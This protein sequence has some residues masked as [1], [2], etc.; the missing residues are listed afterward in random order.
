M[1]EV[2]LQ[3][4]TK[5]FGKDVVAV[6]NLDLTAADGEFV[7]LLGP[8]GCGK[9]TILRMIAG[10]ET[11]TEGEILIGGRRVTDVQPRDR[12]IAMVFQNYALYPHMTA[13]ENIAFGLRMRKMPLEEIEERIRWAAGFLEI[14]DMLD[15]R[16]RALSG[17]ERQRIALGRAL[18]RKPSV[19]LFD[20]P[21]SN[22]DARLRVQMRHEIIKIHRRVGTTA[23][24]VTHDQAEAMTMGDH[25]AVL[26]NG[27]LQQM[28]PP[29]ELYGTPAN[30]FVAEFV[31]NPAI[32]ILEGIFDP[33]AG[34]FS[35]AAFEF[36]WP[37]AVPKPQALSPVPLHFGIRPENVHLEPFRDGGP[38]IEVDCRVERVD[39]LGGEHHVYLSAGDGLIVSRQGGN[40]PLGRVENS[41]IKVRFDP[42]EGHF[43]DA[44]SG[45]NIRCVE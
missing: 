28:A 23:I 38:G 41:R 27:R 20:E 44:G 24:Y 45:G 26:H 16:P 15:R 11:V 18:V 29:A 30:R 3:G 10:L 43:F 35:C 1:A 9:T 31:G 7:V 14:D 32:N 17:G 33:A 21:L 8:S 37:A 6:D 40:L 12:D 34:T 39:L 19:F 4:V 5:R 42:E 22:L 2:R 13:Y 25:I 36:P